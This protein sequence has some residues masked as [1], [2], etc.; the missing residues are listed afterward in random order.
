MSAENKIKILELNSSD[1]QYLHKDFHGALCYAIKYLDEIFGP[2]ATAQ[3]LRQ[4]GRENFSP[5]STSLQQEGLIALERHFK[6]IFEL[7]GGEAQFE[8]DNDRLAIHVSKCPAIAHLK[9]TGQLF[10][11][12]YCESTVNINE[13][14]C[15][16]A[17]YKCSCDY[18]AGEGRCIQSFWKKGVP[19]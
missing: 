19:K 16:A 6:H 12:R 17:G 5:L 13:G 7:E 11:D 8:C 2:D 14:I 3:Y 18:V 4:V 15:E 1:N 9:S 10:T